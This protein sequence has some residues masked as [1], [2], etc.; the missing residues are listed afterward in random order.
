MRGAKSPQY[1]AG[2]K[3]FAYQDEYRFAY[4]KTDAFG[5]ENCTYNLAD[6]KTRPLPKTNEH[7]DET[8]ELGDLRDICRIPV[9]KSRRIKQTLR[10]SPRGRCSG[11]RRLREETS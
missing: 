7:L 9:F 1:G 11:R 3:Q 2:Q 10:Y 8:L 6:R 4:T 5:F